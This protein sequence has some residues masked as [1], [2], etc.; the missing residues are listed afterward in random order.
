MKPPARPAGRPRRRRPTPRRRSDGSNVVTSISAVSTTT[1]PRVIP[2]TVS[3]WTGCGRGVSP[4]PTP[5]W[6]SGS[7]K[8]RQAPSSGAG[9]AM[10]WSASTSSPAATAP[11]CGHHRQAA[12]DRLL[13]L[14][15]TET[16]TLVTATR[17]VSRHSGARVLQEALATRRYPPRRRRL[18]PVAPPRTRSVDA[19]PPRR[20]PRRGGRDDGY[21]SGPQATR[22]SRDLAT[23]SWANSLTLIRARCRSGLTLSCA[24]PGFV[25]RPVPVECC[26]TSSAEPTN[27]R[28]S[29]PRR[30][31]R[32]RSRAHH[33]R[34][35]RRYHGV[36]GKFV[37]FYGPGVATVPL[38]SRATIG[39]MSLEYGSTCA[40]FPIDAETLRYLQF[41]GRP[42]NRSPWSRRTAEEQ[43]LFHEPGGC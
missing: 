30:V 36:V 2:A 4:K 35:A 40:L 1:M 14:A 17:D 12:L 13:E 20:H 24:P 29:S 21:R 26:W 6:T 43:G 3:S 15:R 25:A 11:S 42:P 22:R 31:N 34:A 9:T 32:H 10:T 19:H 39:D 28:R 38:K 5:R 23:D 18:P 41:T 7:K 37:E 33:R 27:T 8:P 16:I